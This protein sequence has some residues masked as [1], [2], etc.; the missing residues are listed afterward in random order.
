LAKADECYRLTEHAGGFFVDIPGAACDYVSVREDEPARW[1][2]CLRSRLAFPG[3][4][5]RLPDDGVQLLSIARSTD[6]HYP[7]T[8][9]RAME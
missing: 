3:N 6:R 7:T 8:L 4:Q 1:Q 9:T 5:C 2:I